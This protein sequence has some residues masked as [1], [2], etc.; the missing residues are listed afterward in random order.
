[1][2]LT[3]TLSTIPWLFTLVWPVLLQAQDRPRPAAPWPPPEGPI[4]MIIDTDAGAEIDDQYALALALGFP[5]RI[6]IEGFVAAHFGIDGGAKGI[7]K[8][9]A[10][11]QTVLEKA[12]MKGRFPV[13]RGSDPIVYRDRVPES[14]G[15]DFIVERA[16]AA[17]PEN[18]LWLVMLGPA[19][20]G[21]A[22]L[23]K[24]PSIADR[25]IVLWHGRTQW[26]VRC[27]NYNAFNDIKAAQ[28]LFEVPVRFVLFDTGT[29]L[30]IHPEESGRRFTPISELGK[31]L[32]EI[33]NRHKHYLSP[34]KGM[35]D[36][37][38]IVAVV[39]PN[40]VRWERTDAPRV[41][42]DLRYDFTRNY[43]EIVRI[44]HV[45]RDRS[46]DLLEESLR[47]LSS[48]KPGDLPKPYGE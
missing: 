4:R 38:D 1:M 43:G 11:I 6:K 35:F 10:E 48:K 33:R 24:E 20:D 17:T 21:A 15:V 34:R 47:R 37:G 8:S 29:H 41:D 5:E 16:K 39:D 19:T 3:R 2:R 31:Y 46:F 36:L 42:H 40:A 7:D 45:E 18:P 27:W 13:K 25:M 9:F 26:P 28:L 44:Y 12:G 22:A 30:T 32:H 14:E 23:L